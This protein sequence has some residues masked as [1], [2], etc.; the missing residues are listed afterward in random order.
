MLLDAIATIILAGMMLIPLVNV[1]VGAV[2]GAALGGVPGALAGVIGAVV[3]T[4]LE[5]VLADRLG[6]REVRQLP[7]PLATDGDE[8]TLVTTIGRRAQSSRTETPRTRPPPNRARAHRS[9]ERTG[10][11]TLLR[12]KRSG[13]RA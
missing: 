3:V 6:W 5:R 7:E 12:E 4:L 11:A 2:A 1:F 8:E 9:R 10:A 13:A